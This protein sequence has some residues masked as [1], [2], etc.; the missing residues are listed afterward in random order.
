MS[1]TNR[2]VALGLIV[3]MG[4]VAWLSWGFSDSENAAQTVPLPLP[5][6]APLVASSGRV[7]LSAQPTVASS[8]AVSDSSA[9]MARSPASAA[10]PSS[11]PAWVRNPPDLG[12]TRVL[13]GDQEVLLRDKAHKVLGTKPSKAEATL[14]QPV[15]LVRDETSGQVEYFQSGL[16]FRL[17]TGSDYPAFLQ[18]HPQMQLLFHN[19]DFATVKVD[20]GFIAENFRML[21]QDPRV[22]FV[23]FLIPQ[24]VVKPK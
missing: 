14:G 13:S 9:F 3:L 4:G 7:A 12:L 20:A 17:V 11:L 19:T 15:L 22:T 24:R 10:A 18:E 1:F 23:G 6:A 16:Q 21:S 2:T 8:G 5:A